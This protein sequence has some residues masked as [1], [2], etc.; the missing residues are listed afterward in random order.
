MNINNQEG[1]EI[2]T[3][4]KIVK[5]KN[6]AKIISDKIQE[7]YQEYTGICKAIGFLSPI[8][9]GILQIVITIK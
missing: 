3:E 9:I 2:R 6:K 4:F 8:I 1:G 5:R 7:L